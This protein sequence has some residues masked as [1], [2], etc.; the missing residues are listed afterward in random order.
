M[1]AV[2]FRVGEASTEWNG[3]ILVELVNEQIALTPGNR[4]SRE[5]R[6]RQHLTHATEATT[7]TNLFANS[8]S[9]RPQ[10]SGVF[11][12]SSNGVCGYQAL[13][14][15]TLR[16]SAC[17]QVQVQSGEMASCSCSMACACRCC[18]HLN[19]KQANLLQVIFPLF[20]RGISK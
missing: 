4:A 6:R 16:V 17:E 5:P 1:H 12:A 13:A 15:P 9:E 19:R 10:Y 20:F 2:P 14:L 18:S 3:Y 7:T 11:S 8:L